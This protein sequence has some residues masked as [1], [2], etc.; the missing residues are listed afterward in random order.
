MLDALSLREEFIVTILRVLLLASTIVIYVFTY[1]AV[2]AQGIN[3]PTVALG[4]ILALN[5]RSQ[6]DVDLVIHLLLL[7]TWI[8][9][10]EGFSMKGHIFGFL[11]IVMGGMF[12]FPYL[13]HAIYAANGNPVVTLLGGHQSDPA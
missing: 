8:S 1:S 2:A 13:L 3:W 5:W 4:D 10:R 9:W 11:S 6:F 7:A 12:S